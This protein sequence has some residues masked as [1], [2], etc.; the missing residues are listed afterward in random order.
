M[1]IPPLQ[2]LADNTYDFVVSFQVIEHIQDDGLYLKEIHRVLKPGGKALITTPNRSM[3]LTRNPWHIREYL[4]KEL[5]S[6]ASKTFRKVE[7]KGITGNEK[8]MKY[9]EENKK[10]V[11]R[12]TRWDFLKLQY[13]LPAAVLRV[14]YE[15]LN[16]WNRNKLQDTN[17]TLVSQIHHEDYIAVDDATNALDLFLIAEK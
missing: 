2:G 17:N 16:R 9:Y 10:S 5:S 3:S 6:L 8:V 4:P 11:E 14:P 15:L 13:R 12:I 7:M 1:N